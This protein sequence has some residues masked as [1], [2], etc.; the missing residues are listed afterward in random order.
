MKIGL[1]INHYQK[2]SNK[3]QEDFL[4]NLKFTEPNI[5]ETITKAKDGLKEFY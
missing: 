4:N 1:K 3:I 5:N 2:N